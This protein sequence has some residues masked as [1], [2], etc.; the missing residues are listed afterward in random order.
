MARGLF[1]MLGDPDGPTQY[2]IERETQVPHTRACLLH[3]EGWGA[4]HYK[5]TT[6]QDGL[7]HLEPSEEWLSYEGMRAAATRS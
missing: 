1:A 4:C 5:N 2:S 3:R 6:C 7:C